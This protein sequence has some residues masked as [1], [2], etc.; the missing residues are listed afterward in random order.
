MAC[1]QHNCWICSTFASPA[2]ISG[3]YRNGA[4]VYLLIRDAVTGR[5][6][7][8]P[9]QMVRHADRDARIRRVQGN[10]NVSESWGLRKETG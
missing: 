7:P 2:I 6:A 4:V 9:F 3:G 10:C 1:L 5:A 8:S